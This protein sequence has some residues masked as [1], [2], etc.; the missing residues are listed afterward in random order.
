[1][2]GLRGLGQTQ[3]SESPNPDSVASLQLSQVLSPS[4]TPGHP[5]K[6][7]Y[8]DFDITLLEKSIS[9]PHFSYALQK[10]WGLTSR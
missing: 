4:W 10:A 5:T 8:S 6:D 1:M 3:A 2:G 9:G 7:L